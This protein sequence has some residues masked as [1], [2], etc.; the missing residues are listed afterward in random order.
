[1]E[2]YVLGTANILSLTILVALGYPLVFAVCCGD[3]FHRYLIVGLLGLN[4]L[5]AGIKQLSLRALDGTLARRPAGARACDLFCMG[6]PV[7]GQAGFPS[8]HMA[9]VAMFTTALWMHTGDSNIFW[10]GVVWVAGM[11]WS[12]WIKQCHTREQIVAGAILGAG[13]GLLVAMVARAKG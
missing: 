11:G 9:T 6:G 1:M 8:G 7:G 10:L 2:S 3:R 13:S 5:V 4:A 12:R